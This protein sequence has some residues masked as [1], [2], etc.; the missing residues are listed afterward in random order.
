MLTGDMAHASDSSNIQDF[1]ATMGDM[2]RTGQPEV[3]AEGSKRSQQVGALAVK[4]REH[5]QRSWPEI[6]KKVGVIAARCIVEK[7]MHEHHNHVRV[8]PT[9]KPASRAENWEVCFDYI[10]WANR[11]PHSMYHTTLCTL[12][13]HKYLL[14]SMLA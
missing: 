13:L 5:W 2:D 12:Y 7:V 3:I 6:A 1:F 14:W 11:M 10:D 8:K 4:D 9:Q